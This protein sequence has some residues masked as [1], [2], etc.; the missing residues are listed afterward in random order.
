M[1]YYFTAPKG[2]SADDFAVDIYGAEIT[3]SGSYI[4]VNISDIAAPELAMEM[5]FDLIYDGESVGTLTASP[6]AYV[7]SVLAANSNED[8]VNLAKAIYL[9]G[10]AAKGF[11]IEQPM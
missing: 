1:R 11:F 8:L 10:T 2:A 9:Y 7:K 6:M 5:S 3:K 4:V